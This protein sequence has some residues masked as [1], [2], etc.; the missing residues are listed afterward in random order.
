MI[1]LLIVSITRRRDQI[2]QLTKRMLFL[3]LCLLPLSTALP[4]SEEPQ[5]L[6]PVMEKKLETAWVEVREY[7]AQKTKDQTNDLQR[8]YAKEF[9]QYYREYPGTPTG[10]HAG[11]AAFM[12]WG[13]LGATVQV[14]EAI[15]HVP[16]ESKLWSNIL[17]SIG[18]AYARNERREDYLTLLSRLEN[19]LTHPDSRSE[20]FLALGQYAKGKGH[21]KKAEGYFEEV[22]GI[23][24]SP[25]NVQKAERALYEIRS[26]NVGQVAPDFTAEAIDGTSVTLSDLLGKVVLLEFWA[27][28][29]GPC[30]P[31]IPHLK[32][33][34]EELPA[35][36]FQIVGVAENDDLQ[37]LRQ[38]LLEHKMTWPQ[39]RQNK[40]FEGGT[41]HQDEVLALY[42]VFGIPRSFLIDRDGTIAAKDRR[43]DELEQAARDLV[44]GLEK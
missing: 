5:A 2:R 32:N 27:T 12:M 3:S 20:L 37:K 14:E 25:F 13:N 18:N 30:M 35:S 16:F 36:E 24:A 34:Q 23:E 9:F 15:A 10:T 7:I 6:D 40:K 21:L 42:N 41:L 4:A 38:F 33:L 43:G 19:K 1:H 44:H 39:V 11:Q 31:E 22:L 28:S 29:C 17:N 8:A 26:L